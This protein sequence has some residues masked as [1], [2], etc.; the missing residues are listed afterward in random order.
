[1]VAAP[2]MIEECGIDFCRKCGRDL[3]DVEKELD[4]GRFY[5]LALTDCET[6]FEVNTIVV[7]QR[8]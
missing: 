7:E 4:Y 2:D 5:K 6:V 8:I 1:L 3:S